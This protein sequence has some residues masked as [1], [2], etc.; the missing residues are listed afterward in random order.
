MFEHRLEVQTII[1]A[2]RDEVFA[3]FSDASNLRR[4]TP[5]S[6]DFRIHTPGPLVMAEGLLI[7]YTIRLRSLPMR[8]R[9]KICRWNP[10]MEFVDE[11]LKGPYRKWVH[12][13][14]FFEMADGRTRMRDHVVYALPL[15]PFGEIALPFVR[16][17]LRGIFAYR[18]KAI[19]EIFPPSGDKFP[20]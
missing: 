12:H 6:L 7:D 16:A 10:P 19:L 17:E 15:P 11:Q 13:H 20:Q 2:P 8:W 4:L 18:R 3:F 1:P 9:T 14:L 5:E